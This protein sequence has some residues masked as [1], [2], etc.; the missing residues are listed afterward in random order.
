MTGFDL[1][2]LVREVRDS[3]TIADMELL[4]KEVNRRIKRPDRDTA[5]EQALA[6]VIPQ[7][8]SSHRY[9]PSSPSDHREFD[10]HTPPVAGGLQP[11]RKVAAIRA[12]NGWRKIL[13]N[14]WINVGPGIAGCKILRNCTITDLMYSVS[15]KEMH[16]QHVAAN[17]TIEKRLIT[18]VKEHHVTIVGEL[19][20][21]VLAEVIGGIKP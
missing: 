7:V 19:P 5:L 1:R 17:V 21:P 8:I 14:T 20:E 18:L 13:D 3:M 6:M 15:V 11:S 12:A 4:A 16:I 2:A 9:H 10:T